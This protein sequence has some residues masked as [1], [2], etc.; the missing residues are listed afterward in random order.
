MQSNDFTEKRILVI[1]DDPI[2]LLHARRTFENAKF[3]VLQA[4][5]PLKAMQLLDGRD[6]DIILSD[7][8]MSDIDGYN[9]IWSFR[10]NDKYKK[11]SKIP[12]LAITSLAGSV[13]KAR[14]KEIEADAWIKKPISSD[15]LLEI[16]SEYLV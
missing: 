15:R 11:Y 5:N 13:V 4:D 8:M 2:C 6:I 7:I 12:I 3:Q 16:V 9:L 1:D 14:L 10:K